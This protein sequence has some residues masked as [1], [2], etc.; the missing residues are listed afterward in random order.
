MKICED[1]IDYHACR[2][3][4]ELTSGLYDFA[5]NGENFDNIRIATL[6]EIR[7]ICQMADATKEVLRA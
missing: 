7:G 5:D 6:G 2:L 4:S 3:I 1:N